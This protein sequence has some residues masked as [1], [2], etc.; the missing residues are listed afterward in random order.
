M[1]SM[2][3]RTKE[4][5]PFN[6]LWSRPPHPDFPPFGPSIAHDLIDMED[7]PDENARQT[8]AMMLGWG[9]NKVDARTMLVTCDFSNGAAYLDYVWWDGMS[10]H[11]AM[12]LV[13]LKAK[14]WHY[15]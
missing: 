1:L 6:Y 2:I 9:V 5:D 13:M 4:T 12:T 14:T 8:Y 7:M 10:H 11:E 15:W 3:A